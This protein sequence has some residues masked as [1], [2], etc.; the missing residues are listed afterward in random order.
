MGLVVERREEETKE[1][2]KRKVSEG[3]KGSGSRISY[4]LELFKLFL[5]KTEVLPLKP[6]PNF[7]T[8]KIMN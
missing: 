8:K 1:E 3:W 7:R 2:T 5:H 4:D 6:L